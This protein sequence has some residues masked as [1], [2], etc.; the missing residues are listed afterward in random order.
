MDNSTAEYVFIKSFFDSHQILPLD[1]KTSI[2]SAT[3]PLSPDRASFDDDKSHPGSEVGD[4]TEKTDIMTASSAASF[5]PP[6]SK[7]TNVDIIWK[8]IMDPVLEYCQVSVISCD[9][10][11]LTSMHRTL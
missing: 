4:Y 1:V 6:A 9:R 8:Q 11:A 2:P 5:A 10:A 3:T 7:A